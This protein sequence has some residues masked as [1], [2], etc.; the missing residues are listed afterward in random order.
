MMHAG[1]KGKKGLKWDL[2]YREGPDLTRPCRPQF[3]SKCKT[4]F[5]PETSGLDCIGNTN[6][7]RDFKRREKAGLFYRRMVEAFQRMAARGS[8]NS[9]ETKRQPTLGHGHCVQRKKHPRGKSE[10]QLA[11]FKLYVP[12]CFLSPKP[13]S[14]V[15]SRATD[16][17]STGSLRPFY[18][19]ESASLGMCAYHQQWEDEVHRDSYPL[20]PLDDRWQS[21]VPGTSGSK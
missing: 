8:D 7:T 15:Y 14:P 3:E 9:L 19:V 16:L 21:K 6:A 12:S 2:K 18:Q 5:Q 13:K 20:S 11:A 1:G 4:L 17:Q 10:V